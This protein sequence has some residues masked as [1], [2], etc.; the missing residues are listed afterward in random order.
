MDVDYIGED[1]FRDEWGFIQKSDGEMFEFDDVKD[2]P[3]NRVWTVLDSGD[4]DDGNWYASPGFHV[5]NRVGYVMTK[6]PWT[7][8]LRDAIYFL[9]DFDHEGEDE[10]GGQGD[11]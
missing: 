9:D 11:A 8:E 2:P 1:E 3:V 6:K 5:A 7:N 10:E 4:G